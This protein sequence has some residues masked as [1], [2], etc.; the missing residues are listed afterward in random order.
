MKAWLYVYNASRKSLTVYPAEAEQYATNEYIVSMPGD[1]VQWRFA[2]PG[3][4]TRRMTAYYLLLETRDDEWAKHML[5]T[6]R[7]KDVQ[8]RLGTLAHQLKATV[9]E[10]KMLHD[11][12]ISVKE[13]CV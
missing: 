5:T 13:A 11:G 1:V 6:E 8:S 2:L 7:M 10:A 4:I 9:D 3:E 12:D